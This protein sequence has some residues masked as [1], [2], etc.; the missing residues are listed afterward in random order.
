MMIAPNEVVAR[1]LLKQAE[2]CEELGS[3]LYSTLLHQA[4]E[5]V[6]NEGACFAVLHDHHEDSPDSALALRFLGAVHRLV[7]QEKAPQLAAC[8]PS[9]G[10]D[11]D[12]DELW[13]AF[14]AVVRQHTAVLRE[15]VGRPVQTNEVGR[16]APLLGGFLE[17]ARRTGLPLRL[18]E[19]GAAGG[20]ILRWD[21]Y[22][23]EAR[24]EGWGDPHSPVRICGAFGD[25]HPPFDVP[26]KI[27]ERRG[28]DASPIDPGTEEGRL[29]LQSYVWP[30]QVERFRQ[31][32]AAIEV[33]GRVPAQ[34]DQATATDW[35]EAALADRTSGVATVVYHSI[36]W[37]YLSNVDRALIE[38]VMAGAGEAATEDKPLAWLRFEPGG[39][40]AE[41]RLQLWPG[42]EDRLLARS[43]FHGKPVQWLGCE[44]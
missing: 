2:W 38:R 40:L 8:Y 23:Y 18:L 31:L 21:R 19:I 26:V 9:A 34:V 4:A 11:S 30:D 3:R 43:G 29:T 37:Q 27:A 14:H 20:L 5:D 33:A 22:R 42:S 32:A 10:G 41:V 39:N 24:D 16:C 1:R 12:C 25:V 6:R 28:C 15:L 35:V 7:L 36:V 13:P 44:N 17:V